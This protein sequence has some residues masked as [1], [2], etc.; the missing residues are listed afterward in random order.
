MILVFDAVTLIYLGKAKVLEKLGGLNAQ[1]II[2]SKVYVEVV[3]VGIEKGFEEAV[4]VK[5]LV[6][7]KLFSVEECDI[8]QLKIKT[9]DQ[10]DLEVLEL[11]KKLKGTI[12]TDDQ[13]LRNLASIEKV[14][15][16]GSV[17]LLF[18]LLKN[19]IITKTGLKST[20]D[21]MIDCGWYC[22]TDFYTMIINKLEH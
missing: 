16:V 2:P 19:K 1:L 4:Y 13:K 21:K 7:S 20:V 22:S 17:F 11:A 6:D 10:A 9:L 12:V 5:G 15:N 14:D 3:D 8:G 18:L